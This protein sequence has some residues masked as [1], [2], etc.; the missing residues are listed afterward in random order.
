MIT[1]IILILPLMKTFFT[2][3]HS[4]RLDAI[5]LYC[6]FA[7]TYGSMYCGSYLCNHV[8]YA[9]IVSRTRPLGLHFCSTI[10]HQ[11]QC[12]PGALVLS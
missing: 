11:D 3:N 6:K 9:Q 4:V 1:A 10:K 12:G 7:S 2:V 8:G 5:I